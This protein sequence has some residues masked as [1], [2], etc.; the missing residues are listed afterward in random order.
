MD[1]AATSSSSQQTPVETSVDAAIMG[2]YACTRFRRNEAV[3][4]APTKTQGNKST[5][6]TIDTTATVSDPQ[7]VKEAMH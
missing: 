3:I 6:S 1:R 2:R 7:V 5:I 4:A